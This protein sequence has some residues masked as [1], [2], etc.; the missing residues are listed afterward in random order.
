MR[1]GL[2]SKAL[3][4]TVAFDAWLSRD[5]GTSS[6]ERNAVVDLPNKNRHTALHGACHL[7]NEDAVRLLPA[8][9]A[10][11]TLEDNQGHTPPPEQQQRSQQQRFAPHRSTPTCRH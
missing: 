4:G 10:S 1:L 7:E 8:A 6:F 2:G 9:G 11:T 5:K 3:W